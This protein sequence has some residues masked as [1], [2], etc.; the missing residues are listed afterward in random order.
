MT[1]FRITN[2]AN[3]R[4][5][6]FSLP[7]L[8]RTHNGETNNLY[9]PLYGAANTDLLR[10]NTDT[11]FPTRTVAPR[12]I[13]N[14]I[15]KGGLI[16]NN[17]NL[18]NMM[19]LWGQFLDHEIDLT[20]DSSGESMNMSTDDGGP[21]EEYPGRTIN[22]NRSAYN[23][24]NGEREHPN[25][26]SSFVDA[27]N[28]YGTDSTRVYTLRLMDGSGKLKTTTSDNS[29][30]ILPYNTTNL[31]NAPNSDS[32]YFLGGDIR[33]NENVVL[34]AMHTLFVREHNRQCDLYKQK[35]P[36]YLG[37]DE[38]IYEYSRRM[39]A[40]M[41]QNITYNEFLPALLG[42]SLPPYT[43]YDSSVNPSVCIEFST[44]GYRLG[45]SMLSSLI[46]VGTGGGSIELKDAFFNPSYVQTNGVNNLLIGSVLSK[47]QKID[48][49]D[50][51]LSLNKDF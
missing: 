20:P 42:E 1:D 39:V 24:V 49:V 34:T 25:V 33:A 51:L 32:S 40:G 50:Q 9:N 8:W 41:M 4:E 10:V 48:N 15:C 35:H 43:G 47:M 13:S 44:V 5:V 11:S 6:D 31:D 30:V 19:W 7:Y 45:H 27:T 12:L 38:M 23:I 46:P 22:F 14:V 2:D 26:I 18:S 21:T 29:E 3:I 37:Q 17:Y 16:E 28:V 36:E